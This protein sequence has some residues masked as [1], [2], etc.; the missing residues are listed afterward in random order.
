MSQLATTRQMDAELHAAMLDAGMADSG[1]Y[2][3]PGANF[4]VPVR[5]Y[6]DRAAQVLG[7]FGQVVGRRIEIGL[8]LEDVPAPA[9]GGQVYVPAE[10]A[11]YQLVS[12]P[13]GDNTDDGSL[14]RWVVRRV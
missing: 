8:L 1:H 11:T 6:I 7:E 3:A 5:I 13:E 2:T 14:S 9:K 10:G 12:Q 4:D